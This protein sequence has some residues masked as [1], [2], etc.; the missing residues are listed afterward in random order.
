MFR[1]NFDDVTLE[2]V[3][4]ETL[5][6]TG[7]RVKNFRCVGI[8]VGLLLAKKYKSGGISLPWSNRGCDKWKNGTNIWMDI[9]AKI[10]YI[11]QS[12]RYEMQHLVQIA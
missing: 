4:V 9:S 7:K 5:P 12:I 10:Y 8:L 6:I 11:K 2:Q 3:M 1:Q